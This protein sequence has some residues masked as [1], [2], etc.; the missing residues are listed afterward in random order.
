[1]PNCAILATRYDVE[2]A[3]EDGDLPA[4]SRDIMFALARR[5]SQGSTVIPPE[6]SPS[7]TR[8]ARST[9]WHR[10]TVMRHL[11]DLEAAG[12]L[13]RRRPPP[14]L[15]RARYMTTA[16]VVHYPQ[17]GT[18]D[19]GPGAHDPGLET[20]SP[21]LETGTAPGRGTGPHSQIESDQVSGL[22]TDPEIA[23]VIDEIE[24]RTGQLVT[25][26]FAA[27][28]RDVILARPGI[29]NRAAYL[30]RCLATDPD[31][32]RFLPTSQPPAEFCER[33]TKTGHEKSDCPY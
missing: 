16:Y 7:L 10:R 30:R 28:A 5:M 18:Q 24:K 13:E 14:E 11:R 8:L 19:P 1:M 27:K 25:L 15:A 23:I 33:C 26:E 32:A 29:R 3:V 17:V 12:I 20:A 31:P 22:V 9:G 6:F 21:G 4:I 2:R